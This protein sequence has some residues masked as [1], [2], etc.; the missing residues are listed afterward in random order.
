MKN[1]AMIFML[2]GLADGVLAQTQE[3]TEA[4]IVE[5]TDF[6]NYGLTYTIEGDELVSRISLP[7]A[8]GGGTIKKSIPISRIT[9]ISFV[10]EKEKFLSYSLKCNDSC[11]Y[12]VKLSSDEKFEEEEQQHQFLFEMYKKVDESFPPRMNKAL[13]RLVELHGGKAK[14]VPH[15]APKEAF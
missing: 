2:F 7:L 1:I 4:W 12:M 8:G 10:H 9:K 15:K 14:I 6:Y 5:Q 11:A 13:L 3:E